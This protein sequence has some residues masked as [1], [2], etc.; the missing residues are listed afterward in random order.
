MFLFFIGLYIFIFLIGHYIS[1]FVIGHYIFIFVIGHY[2]FIFVIGNYISIFVI[3][4]TTVKLVLQ[5]AGTGFYLWLCRML[6][7]LF[8][9]SLVPS[10]RKLALVLGNG[11]E[12]LCMSRP[13]LGSYVHQESI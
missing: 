4:Q 9:G 3:V 5:T 10:C 6:F 13:L 11:Y 8:A 7:A 1:I 12:R 2:I